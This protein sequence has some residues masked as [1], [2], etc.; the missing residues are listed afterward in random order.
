MISDSTSSV[1]PKLQIL[2]LTHDNT[3]TAKELLIEQ[4]AEDETLSDS[5]SFLQP[6]SQIQQSTNDNKNNNSIN[7]F[8]DEYTNFERHLKYPEP[9]KKATNQRDKEKLPNAISSIEWRNYYIKKEEMKNK[10]LANAKRKR[11][12]R[13]AA[14]EQKEATKF[15]KKNNK[16]K[17][18]TEETKEEDK[19]DETLLSK[20]KI[21]CFAYDEELI[22]DIEEDD[23][24]N[25]GCDKCT[26]WFHLR[27]T[28]L[29]GMTY[30]EAATK[31]YLCFACS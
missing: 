1:P 13:Q 23:E 25:I 3:K 6:G 19:K 26:R 11:E 17:K 31:D 16:K 29:C 30:T 22:S 4:I 2:Q 27:C 7:V 21:N 10:K 9:L 8:S 18:K 12:E 15:Q 20:E 24:K 28:E 5:T 14:K